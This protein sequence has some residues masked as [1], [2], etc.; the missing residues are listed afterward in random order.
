VSSQGVRTGSPEGGAGL[1]SGKC[2]CSSYP[3]VGD[4]VD[5]VYVEGAA[6]FERSLG[7]STSVEVPAAR[8]GVR[9]WIVSRTPDRKQFETPTTM[10]PAAPFVFD[11]RAVL[12]P[13]AIYNVGAMR[14]VPVEGGARRECVRVRGRIDSASGVGVLR[15]RELG[16]PPGPLMSA[17]EAFRPSGGQ[18]L[19][20][21]GVVD[22]AQRAA[23]VPP[24]PLVSAYTQP[25][26]YESTVT[27]DGGVTLRLLPDVKL[28]A[29]EGGD[30][31][32]P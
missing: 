13:G 15:W 24:I 27:P 10:P 12:A 26:T 9:V 19:R 4:D 1:F 8:E 7:A 14:L 30:T 17:D 29:P 22:R 16:S 28:C 3:L 5:A 25:G 6:V 23:R 21:I 20:Q 31:A 32:A 2:P 11:V 18:D